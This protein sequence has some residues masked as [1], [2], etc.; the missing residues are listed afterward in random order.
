[1]I[2]KALKKLA[3]VSDEAEVFKTDSRNSTIKTVKTDIDSF[4]ERR[5][6]GYGIRLIKDSR[7]GFYFTNTLDRAIEA[8]AKVAKVAEKDEFQVL[9]DRQNYRKGKYP[10][11]EMDVDEGL[12]MAQEMTGAAGGF[13]N[14]KPTTG[15]VS[16]GTTKVTIANTNGVFG[17]KEEQS[18]S[19]YIGV[20]AGG[21]EPATG[22]HYEV[23]R[24]KDI[25][26][27]KVGNMAGALA[28]DSLNP[29]GLEAGRRKVILRPMAVSELFEYT[30]I[31]SFNADNVQ[32]GRSRLKGMEGEGVFTDV[33]IVD[34]ATLDGALMSEDFDDE[35]V[36]TKRRALVE[37]GVLKGFLFDTYTANKAGRK[38]TGNA[39]RSSYSAL[40]GVAP[41]N[42]VF[43]GKREL[44]DETGALVV[45]G[46]VGAHTSNPVSGDFSCETRNAFLDGVPIKKA[47]VTG[48]IF[49]I[50]KKGVAFGKDTKQYSSVLSP[51][52][53]IPELMVVG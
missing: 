32:R 40:P 33:D 16:W 47:I 23:S 10:A 25:D 14:V 51:S 1:M 29:K 52:I 19:A 7:L 5:S 9:P 53:G 43:T 38:S 27:E 18:I 6:T 15:S 22:F 50:L 11:F 31:P 44:E 13:K 28:R 41:S 3:R 37:G 17:E 48:N 42:F 20:V 36:A 12:G 24:K 30:L 39:G 35:G 26:A 2:E 34:D 8:A 46:L 4:K 45:H 21:A 49:D